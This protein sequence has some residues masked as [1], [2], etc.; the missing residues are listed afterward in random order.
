MAI[1]EQVITNVYNAINSGSYFRSTTEMQSAI[2]LANTQLYQKFRGNMAQYQ[3]NSPKAVLNFGETTI[4]LDSLAELFIIHYFRNNP[5]LIY[6]D[7]YVVDLVENINVEYD[8]DK[9]LYGA[10]ILPSNQFITMIN[11]KVIPPEKQY[12]ICRFKE[13]TESTLGVPPILARYLQYEIFPSNW[14]AVEVAIYVLPKEPVFTLTDTGGPIPQI[15]IT[16]DLVWTQE[17]IPALV[18]LTIQN[19]GFTLQN[20]VLIQGATAQLSEQL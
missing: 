1:L 16:Q 12:P 11:N 5:L 4:T 2:S 17:K 7:G 9:Y 19:L 6:K 18:M 15:N 20:G 10:K 3:K 8:N 13:A 14:T